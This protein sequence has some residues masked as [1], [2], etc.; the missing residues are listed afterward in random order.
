MIRGELALDVGLEGNAC[1]SDLG[2]E[3]GGK[4]QTPRA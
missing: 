1:P 4:A 3:L 2:A